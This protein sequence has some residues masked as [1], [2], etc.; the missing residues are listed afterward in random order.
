MNRAVG[1]FLAIAAVIG[2]AIVLLSLPYNGFFSDHVVEAVIGVV[3][4][5]VGLTYFWKR[6]GFRGLK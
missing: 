4:L 6:S 1:V 3:L 5:A 2:G